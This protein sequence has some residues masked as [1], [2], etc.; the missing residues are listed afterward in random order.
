MDAAQRHSQGSTTVA[1]LGDDPIV[2]RGLQ[3]LL[4][5]VGYE[6]LLSRDSNERASEVELDGVDIVLLGPA[7]R[8]DRR[9]AFLS[10]MKRSP[11]TAC[12]PVL[13]LF[14]VQKEAVTEDMGLVPWPCNI[15]DLVRRIESALRGAGGGGC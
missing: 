4:E 15:E 8:D 11:A 1:I 13:T 3:L 5:G 14:T 10:N 6:P 2:N 7:L 12:I 9:E